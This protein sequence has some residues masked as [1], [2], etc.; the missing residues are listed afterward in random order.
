MTLD[1]LLASID[2]P[3]AALIVMTV[4]VVGTVVSWHRGKDGFD[5]SQCIVD[6]VT[7]RISPEKVA[8]MTV[9]AMMTWGFA[10]LVLQGKLTE[11]FATVYSGVFVLG[12]VG[13]QW[14]TTKK[15]IA[16]ATPG[17]PK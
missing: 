2:A 13:S 17:D 12:R 3:M 10:A 7:Q 5:L 11:W 14:L 4:I 8:Y 9:L 1:A 15:D 16:T 6:S